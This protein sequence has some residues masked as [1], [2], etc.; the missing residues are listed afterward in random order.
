MSLSVAVPCTLSYY[1]KTQK[2][3]PSTRC[4]LKI[5]WR[6]CCLFPFFFSDFKCL[7]IPFRR[8][9]HSCMPSFVRTSFIP[10]LK[11]I[12]TNSMPSIQLLKALQQFHFA[13]SDIFTGGLR[14]RLLLR[15][16]AERQ[17]GGTKDQITAKI[18]CCQRIMNDLPFLS[19]S[20]LSSIPKF[21]LHY[22]L[23]F[24]G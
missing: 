17:S 15:L 22:P 7:R 24:L 6:G 3:H 4:F 13:K 21:L 5:S 1:F 20:L 11:F 16:S 19:H 18:P 2:K 14:S 12:V 10:P 9:P 23:H 8:T